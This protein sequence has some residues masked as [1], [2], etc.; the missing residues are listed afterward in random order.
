MTWKSHQRQIMKNECE[1]WNSKTQG[2]LWGGLEIQV[3]AGHV[4][5]PLQPLRA[6]PCSITEPAGSHL[7]HRASGRLCRLQGLSTAP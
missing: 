3:P 2:V 7:Q 4:T 1:K 6:V 5:A